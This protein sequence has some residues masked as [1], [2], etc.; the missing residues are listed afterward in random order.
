MDDL[1]DMGDFGVDLYAVDESA[2]TNV[3]ADE[4]N[5]ASALKASEKR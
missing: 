2:L 5:H 1:Y 3:D 4:V